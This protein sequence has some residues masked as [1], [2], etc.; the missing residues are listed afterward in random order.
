MI[1]RR[2]ACDDDVV[3]Y[4]TSYLPDLTVYD[5]EE[6]YVSTGLLNVDGDEIVKSTKLGIGFLADHSE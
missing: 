2:P 4:E 6:D 3:E 1:R 5:S